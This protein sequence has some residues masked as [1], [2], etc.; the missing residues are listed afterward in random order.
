MIETLMLLTVLVLGVAAGALL[1]EAFILVPM[2]QSMEASAFLAWYKA[3]ASRLVR[4]FAPLEIAA[5]LAPGLATA[6]LWFEGSPGPADLAY[7]G[8]ATVLSLFVLVSFPLYFRDANASFA[9]ATIELDDVPKELRRWERWHWI[10]TIVA[11]LAFIVSILA[12]RGV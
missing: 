6:V 12:E 5:V 4:F 3:N 9:E 8:S 1:A 11:S 2:W 10:R 7:L